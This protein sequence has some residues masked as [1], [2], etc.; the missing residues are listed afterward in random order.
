MKTVNVSFRLSPGPCSK[1]VL[2]VGTLFHEKLCPSLSNVAAQRTRVQLFLILALFIGGSETLS[3]QVSGAYNLNSKESKIE[4]HLFKGGFLG[5][6]G[7]NHLIDLTRFSGKANFSK[8]GGWTA[9]LTGD[10]ASLKV[11]DPWGNPSERVQVQDTMLGPQQIDANHFP[12]IELHSVS[13]D[14]VDH[15]TVWHLV[16]NVKL[17]G[18]TR[19]VQFS[20]DC[21]EIG[22]KLQI[23]GKK[24]FKLTDFNIQPYSAALGTVKVKNDFLVTYNVVL[25]R[26]H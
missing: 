21:H 18:V 7:D 16:A 2:A 20:L 13:F 24:M 10:A 14:P 26:I 25:D 3:A 6:F 19:K 11:I 4:I 12:S 8:A 23:Q 1:R 15:D 17:H 5:K 22:N 9:D